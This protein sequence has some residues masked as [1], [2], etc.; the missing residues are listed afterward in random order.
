[1]IEREIISNQLAA[2]ARDE[3]LIPTLLHVSGAIANRAAKSMAGLHPVK[4]LAGVERLLEIKI[5]SRNLGQ[6]HRWIELSE[7]D[8]KSTRPKAAKF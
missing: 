7:R 8:V 4:H 6:F 3:Q 2:A 5:R 1:M